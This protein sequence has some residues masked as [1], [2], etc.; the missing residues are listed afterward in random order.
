MLK[1]LQ[2]RKVFESGFWQKKRVVAVD[3]VDLEIGRGETI[4]LVGESGS[5]KTT[6]GRM[7]LLLLAPTRGQIFLDGVELTKLGKKELR[8]IRKNLQLIPQHPEVSLD[9]R[10]KIYDS[11][12]ELMRIHHVV[13][14][15]EEE[16][17]KVF[18]LLEMVGLKEE[19]LDRY[20]HELS[21]GELQ[22][23]VI[24][25]ALSLNPKFIVADEPTSMLD[26]SVQAQILNLLMDLQKRFGVSYLFITHD[27]EVARRVSDYIAIIYA[28]QI[29]E[30]AEAGEL[31]RSPVHP[32]TQS[33]LESTDLSGSPAVFSMDDCDNST[34]EGCKYYT[35]CRQRKDHCKEQAPGFLEV[36]RKHRVRCL[37]I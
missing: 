28:G 13:K 22:R 18:E 24:A 19:H 8:R 7:L 34:A 11:I 27:L 20:P 30:M 29:I 23:V 2:L 9:P 26:V 25:R 35:R 33:L 3:G 1:A 32:Y 16:R 12:A 37:C 31:F 14:N 21:G 4:G 10:W 17:E 15:R 5:G 36:N 6:L